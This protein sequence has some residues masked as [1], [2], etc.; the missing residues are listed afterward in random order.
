MENEYAYHG[1][2]FIITRDNVTVENVTHKIFGE[3]EH[4]APYEAFFLV[5]EAVNVTI[6]DCLLTPHKTYVTYINGDLNKPSSMG[7]YDLNFTAAI[8]TRLIN[9]TQSIDINDNRYWGLMG[10]NFCKDFYLENCVMSRFD[11]HMGVTNVTIKGSTFGHMS[12]QLIGTGDALIEDSVAYGNHFVNLRADYGSIWDG[13]LTIR[14]C[15]WHPRNPKA[16]A[17]IG[18]QNKGEHD[19]GYVCRMPENI[20]I[21]GMRVCDGEFGESAT[22]YALPNYDP[23]YTDGKP[24][25]YVPPKTV[26]IA[27][28]V[29]ES[30]KKYLICANAAQYK[31]TIINA[32]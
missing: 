21:D 2:N 4:G 13:N 12:L 20:V 32:K 7:S 11:A 23:T 27:N 18:A 6:R 10:S 8:N 9:I 3:G 24:Y 26:E 14:N 5:S 29:S 17:V 1:R 25:P 16:L 28:I 22:L 19:F 30:G 31:S 15:V